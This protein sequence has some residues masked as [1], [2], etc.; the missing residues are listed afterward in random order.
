[1]DALTK[2]EL[3]ELMVEAMG[4]MKK[5]QSDLLGDFLF[6]LKDMQ[7]DS[8]ELLKTLNDHK[9]EDVRIQGE[10]NQ[11]ISSI[12]DNLKPINSTFSE[13]GKSIVQWVVPF[14]LAFL[15]YKNK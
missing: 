13:V 12:K 15:F 9:L 7:N 8:K 1:M 10:I 6:R 11:E 14:A 3:R 4:A 5:E 2:N